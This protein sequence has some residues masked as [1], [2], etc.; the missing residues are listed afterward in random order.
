MAIY[1]KTTHNLRRGTS[2][3]PDIN[4]THFYL[5]HLLGLDPIHWPFISLDH[6]SISSCCEYTSTPMVRVQGKVLNIRSSVR[7]ASTTAVILQFSPGLI[8]FI[9]LVTL[10]ECPNRTVGVLFHA[11]SDWVGAWVKKRSLYRWALL[12]TGQNNSVTFISF[13]YLLWSYIKYNYINTYHIGR[14]TLYLNM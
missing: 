9:C 10:C 12:F 7:S 1:L 3:M 8:R 2:I 4:S 13:V 6:A 11:R 14:V 5:D